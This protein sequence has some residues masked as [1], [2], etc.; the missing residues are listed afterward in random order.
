MC[1][2]MLTLTTQVSLENKEKQTEDECFEFLKFMSKAKEWDFLRVN[3]CLLLNDSQRE[4]IQVSHNG[5]NR[6]GGLLISLLNKWELFS[7]KK[8]NL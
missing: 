6:G 4:R 3:F 1:V 2:N 7:E 5:L 8:T